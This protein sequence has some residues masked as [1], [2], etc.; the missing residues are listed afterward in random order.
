MDTILE[1]PIEEKMLSQLREIADTRGTSVQHIAGEVLQRFVADRTS[2]TSVEQKLDREIA[3]YQAMHKTL[4]EQYPGQYVAIHEGQLLGAD[5]DQVSLFQ[6]VKQ[7]YPNK[8]ILI[9]QV[10]RQAEPELRVRSPRID[11]E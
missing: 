8:T 10:Q 1:L 2:A 7:Q 6:Q 11:H 9:R 4:F 5:V 3:A